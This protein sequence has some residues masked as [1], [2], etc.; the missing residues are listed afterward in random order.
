MKEVTPQEVRVETKVKKQDHGCLIASLLTIL[1]IGVS[2]VTIVAIDGLAGF[3]TGVILILLILTVFFGSGVLV[4][5]AVLP[6]L[7]LE[8]YLL[9]YHKGLVFLTLGA[10]AVIGFIRLW[11]KDE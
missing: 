5:A 8:M 7:F 1:V 10:I 3:L 6:L 2:M 11:I 4:V 9:A